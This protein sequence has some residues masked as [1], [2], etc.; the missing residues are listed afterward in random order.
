MQLTTHVTFKGIDH[1][2]A[3]EAWIQEWAA[4]LGRSNRF[5]SRCEVVV[6]APHRHHRHGRRWHVSVKLDLPGGP[7]AVTRDP[8]IDEA[9]EDPYVAVRDSFRA[10]RRQLEDSL[11]R[12][13]H[14]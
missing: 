11:D 3:L 5:V 13:R 9:H 7:L 6:E 2:D 8:G 4:K 10:V 1:S 14:A 12:R